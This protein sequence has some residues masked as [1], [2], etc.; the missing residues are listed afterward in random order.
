MIKKVWTPEASVWP[1]RDEVAEQFLAGIGWGVLFL[2]G[3]FAIC[4]SP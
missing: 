4:V 3:L 2:V 1:S